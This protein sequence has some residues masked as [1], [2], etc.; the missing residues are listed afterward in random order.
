MP[1]PI[2]TSNCIRA[3]NWHNRQT[4][5]NMAQTDQTYGNAAQTDQ[6]PPRQWPPRKCFNCDKPRHLARQCHAPRKT[7]INSVINE[8]EDMTH[9]QS[10]ITLDGIL[11]NALAMFDRLPEQLKDDFVQQYEGKSPNFQDV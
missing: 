7:Q 6:T 8:L 11:E 1:V 2:D 3:P 9:V 4:Y 10:A 5:G